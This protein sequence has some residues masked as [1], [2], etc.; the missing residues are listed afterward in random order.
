MSGDNNMKIE[1]SPIGIIHSPYKTRDEAP[2]QGRHLDKI[3][4]LELYDEFLEGATDIDGFSHL[5]VI[6][7][8]H[9]SEGYSLMTRT[10]WDEKPHGVFATRSPARPNGI[11]VCVVE[12]LS[13][14]GKFLKVKGLDAVDG[15]P[16]LDIKPY[17][18]G[19]DDAGEVKMGW[20]DGKLK[21]DNQ[22]D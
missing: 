20:L 7:F 1:F 16:L 10:P 2:P 6:Y 15:S 17:A 8:F 3:G 22:G 13:R 9:L 19:I 21:L 11:G 4:E 12:L 14:D 5:L 18:R